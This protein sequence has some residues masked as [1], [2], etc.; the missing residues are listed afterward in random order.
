MANIPPYS[1]E[2]EKSTLGS[3]LIDK[4]AIVK[5][6]DVLSPEDFY[7]DKHGKIYGAIFALFE[8][9]SPIDILTLSAYL[10]DHGMLDKVGG[11]DYLA[12]LSTEVP[13]STHIV[14]YAKIV[15][16]KGTLRRLIKSGQEITSFGYNETEDMED[17]IE[18]AEKSLFG[19]SQTFLKNKFVPIK[20]VLANTYEKITELHDPD[21]KSNYGGILTGFKTMDNILSGFHRSDLVILA[22]RP[23]MGKTAFALNLAQNMAKEDYNVGVFSLE[24]SKEQLVERMFCSL[25]Q[26]D[27]WKLKAGK[28]SEDDFKRI[29][30]VMDKLNKMNIFIDDTAGVTL[31]EVRAKTRRLQMEYGLDILIIDYLQ[32]L[33]TGKSAYN[34]NRVAEIS[35]ISRSLKVLARELNIPIIALSQLSRNLENRHSKVPQLSDLRD[36]GAIEQDADV[37]MMMYRDDYYDPE[38]DRPGILDVFIKKHRNGPLGNVELRFMKEQM[39]YIDL[40][41]N[42]NP[43]Q[44]IPEQPMAPQSHMNIPPIPPLG[45]F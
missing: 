9:H 30:G 43:E 39:R 11:A 6:A 38:S 33:T 36:S 32:L 18:K 44:Y 29:G 1:E 37:V 41:R 4:E 2:A 14:Q 5:V 27:S 15:K 28:L 35:E 7:Y 22:A 42:H 40:D 26:V 8:K 16:H 24:M 21:M 23:S 31:S 25:L 45:E 3:L 12:Q 19:V 10:E 20:D 13:T 34:A 17:V